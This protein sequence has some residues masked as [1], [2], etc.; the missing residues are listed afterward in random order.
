LDFDVVG[1]LTKRDERVERTTEAFQYDVLD[2]LVQMARPSGAPQRYAFLDDGR[3]ASKSDV[4]SYAYSAVAITASDEEP[5]AKP[6]HAVLST[7]INNKTSTYTYDPNGNLTRTPRATFEYTAD[8][9]M[10]LLFADQFRWS[11]FDYA[12][13]GNRYR[14]FARIGIEATENLYIGSYERITEF[15]GPLT[16]ARLGRL[17]RHRHTLSNGSGVFAT[18]EVNGEYTDI[19]G[20][21]ALPRAPG[22]TARNI[23]ETTKV[24]YLHKDQLGSVLRITDENARLAAKFWYD[25]WGKR[26]GGTN[27]PANF[28]PGQKL[29][30][31]WD[32]GFTGHEHIDE[33]SVVHMNGRVYENTIAN[34]TSVDLVNQALGDSQTGNGYQYA[35]RNPL[36]YTDPSGYFSIGGFFAAVV[37]FAVGGPLGAAAAYAL[38]ETSPDVKKFVDDNWRQAVII[39]ATVAVA[40]FTGG[41]GLTLMQAIL[42]GAAVGA[43]VRREL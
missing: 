1:N 27:D 28:R 7:T 6:F 8:N 20:Q 17:V 36:R 13:S 11:R 14:Q 35:K 16:G 4:G 40:Y 3:F 29:D 2:R 34:F 21:P 9:R 10:N 43:I 23:I 25:P 32:R 38:Y 18:V 22:V 12:P 24:W 42:S 30:D 19:V 15:A 41:A 37:G 33:Y 26:S 39:A 5:T 31:T